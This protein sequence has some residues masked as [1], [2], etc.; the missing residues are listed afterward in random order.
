MTKRLGRGLA[1]LIQTSP[2][3]DSAINKE[4]GTA[5]SAA[6]PGFVSLRLE[7][8]KPSRFQPRMQIQGA[9][10]EELATSIR[11]QGI[12]E[13]LLVRPLAHGTYELVAGERRWRAAR[14][15]GLVEVPVLVR[16]LDD[17]QALECALIENVQ[18]ENLNPMEEAHGYA[19]LMEEFQYTQEQVAERVGKQRA[20]VAN[21]LRL[22]KLPDVIQQALRDGALSLGH[23]KVLLATVDAHHQ[24]QLFE[25]CI[26]QG[27]SV[28]TLESHAAATAPTGQPR[29]AL[30][31]TVAD[32]GVRHLEEQLQHALGTRVAVV[33]RQKGGRIVIEYFSPE[34]LERLLKLFGVAVG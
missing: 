33:S 19:R 20:T 25:Q 13:P 32:S 23:A 5:A 4:P 21:L 6:S 9:P 12:L 29:V 31:K 17:K 28:R 30:R 7:Q 34:D 22:L 10:I 27:W 11:R 1:D 15:A 14:M 8:I 2:E 16:Q 18:R 3:Q 24:L 26:A